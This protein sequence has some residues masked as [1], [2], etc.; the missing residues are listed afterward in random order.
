M[1]EFRKDGQKN[2]GSNINRDQIILK[3]GINKE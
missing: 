3:D 2:P 1:G